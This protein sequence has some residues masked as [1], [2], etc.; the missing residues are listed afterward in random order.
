MKHKLKE[1]FIKIFEYSPTHSQ[2]YFSPGRVNLIGEH[3]DYNG[4]LVFPAA[5]DLGT[6]GIVEARAD[7]IF[8][9]YSLNFQDD[10]IITVD[11][12]HL[13]YEEKHRWA[14][15]AKGIIS[16]LILRNFPITHGF[17][18]LVYGT[19]PTASGL[20]SS[21]SL[22]LLTAWICN[23]MFNLN[24]SREY[25]ALLS[26]HV[27]NQYMGMHCGIMDQLVIAKGVK[28]R[29][30]L[31]NTATLETTPV[32]ASFSGFEWVIMNTN[33]PRKTTD[34]KYNERR[35]ECKLA[36]D[37]IKE[38]KNINYLCEL[39]EGELRKLKKYFSDIKIYNRAKHAVTE[40]MRT[41]QSKTAMENHDPITFANLLN[42]SH[43]SLKNDY[44]VTGLELD[45]LVDS[46]RKYGAIGAR[47]TGAGF[48]GCA[49]AL[50]PKTAVESFHQ[51]VGD[52]YFSQTGIKASFHDVTFVD[53]VDIYVD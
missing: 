16:E 50:V 38:H 22:E 23:E 47:V 5:I 43:E 46:A 10:G 7:M 1:K 17:D 9:F 11:K 21:A 42:Q 53:G 48:G 4:G 26:Q 29:A 19:L 41:I 35:R 49:I 39:N 13:L 40:Q 30:L 32:P 51:R 15:Y 33:Y 20:S 36:L 27:E 8:K 44:E 18:L 45:T 6:Y 25:L 24:L 3:I 37:I 14:N 12:N 2:I 28:G 31:M 52:D 34:S